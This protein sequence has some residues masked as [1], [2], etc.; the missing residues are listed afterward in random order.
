METTRWDPATDLSPAIPAEARDRLPY[1]IG[2][3][4]AGDA[5]LP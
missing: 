1:C 4:Q 3:S 5:A 2:T